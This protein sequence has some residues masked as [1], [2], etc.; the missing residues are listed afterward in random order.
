M[1]ALNANKQTVLVVDDDPAVLKLCRTL[2]EQEGFS[3]LP[4][5]GSSEALKICKNHPG[6]VDILVT[7]LVLPPPE[8]SFASG[9][10]EFPHV[11]G[12]E[13]AIRA[14]GMRD[15]LRIVLMSGNIEKDLAGYGIKKG[16]LPFIAKP[17]ENQA[18]VDLVRHALQAPPPAR[19]SLMKEHTGKA[20]GADE[21]FD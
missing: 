19:E 2:F 17:F 12:H 6:S 18:M 4:A 16:S 5:T 20:K 3:V 21:W 11:H 9:D 15:N 13:L 7:D 8:F 14:L 10:N 1:S